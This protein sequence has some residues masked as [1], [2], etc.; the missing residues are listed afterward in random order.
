MDRQPILEVAPEPFKQAIFAADE[1]QRYDLFEEAALEYIAADPVGFVQRTMTKFGYFWWFAPETG[2][3]Y[4]PLWL[5]VYRVLYGAALLLA[6]PG[7]WFAFRSARQSQRAATLLVLLFVLEIA[8][9]QSLFYVEGRHRWLV[10][11]LL[12]LYSAR[13]LLLVWAG[14]SRLVSEASS[15]RPLSSP[16]K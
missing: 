3:L 9:A 1:L 6:V 4:E 7:V 14:L 11:P 2:L 5:E 13:G 15:R 10:E 8:A 12:L 16:S